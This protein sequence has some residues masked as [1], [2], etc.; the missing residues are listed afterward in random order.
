MAVKDEWSDFR[1]TTDQAVPPL[2]PGAK[3]DVPPPPPGYRLDTDIPPPETRSGLTH[4]SSLLT[5]LNP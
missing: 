4:R 1:D 3:L 5:A 2:P